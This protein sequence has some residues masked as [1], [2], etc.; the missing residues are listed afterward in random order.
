[1]L[2]DPEVRAQ[3]DAMSPVGRLASGE[4]AAQTVLA[5][6]TEASDYLVGVIVPVTGGWVQ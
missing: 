1:M 2:S 3:M 6:C 4:M 5:L